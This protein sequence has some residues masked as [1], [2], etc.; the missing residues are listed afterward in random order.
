MWIAAVRTAVFCKIQILKRH[1]KK[2]VSNLVRSPR[3]LCI[4]LIND[5]NFDR[6]KI[7]KAK[8]DQTSATTFV[9]NFERKTL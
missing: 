9:M 1:D 5:L 6:L 3:K 7:M 2:C 8:L 4:F